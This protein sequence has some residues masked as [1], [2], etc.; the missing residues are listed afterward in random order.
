ETGGGDDVVDRER[1]VREDHQPNG[2]A[3]SAGSLLLLCRFAGAWS[4]FSPGE[5]DE[6]P[7]GKTLQ[8][9]ELDQPSHQKDGEPSREEGESRHVA[10]SS[11]LHG[12]RKVGN[13]HRKGES[14]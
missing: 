9:R 3:E 10:Q 4:K 11:P 14:V 2:G 6:K 12:L 8:H 7:G 5:V 13:A 1:E